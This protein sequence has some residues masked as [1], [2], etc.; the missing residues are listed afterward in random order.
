VAKPANDEFDT[1]DFLA[2]AG[3][4][5]RILEVRKHHTIYVQGDAAEAVFFIQKGSV[6]LTVV[7]AQGKEAVVGILLAGQ[8]FGEGCL[9]D[10]SVQSATTTA[11]EDCLVTAITRAAMLDALHS[12]PAFAD[13]FTAY[14]LTRNSRIAEDLADLMLNSSERRLARLLVRLA[15]AGTGHPQPIAV[16]LSQEELAD[17]VGTTRS[18]VSF[19]MNKFRRL[20]FIDYNGNIE[21]HDSLSDTLLR[22]KPGTRRQPR[23]RQA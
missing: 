5:R 21:V 17:M 14:L 8:F 22:G 9:D 2:T 10:H 6:K 23:P 7:S 12:Q 20:G 1:G 3:Q 19:F 16:P 4:G 18:R 13:R 11:T 15:N